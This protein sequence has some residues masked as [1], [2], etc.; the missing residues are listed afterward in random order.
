MLGKNV[1]RF[2]V[3]DLPYLNECFTTN[4]KIKV[5]VANENVGMNLM[6]HI[7]VPLMPITIDQ[8]LSFMPLRDYNLNAVISYVREGKGNKME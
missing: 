8:P 2:T 5:Q 1:L 6:D 7:A 3:D 4:F